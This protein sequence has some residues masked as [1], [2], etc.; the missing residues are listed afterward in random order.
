MFVIHPIIQSLAIL[1]GIYVFVLGIGRF[2]LLHLHHKTVFPWKRHVRLGIICLVAW[3]GGMLGGM[4]VV[5]RAWGVML[6]SGPHAQFALYMV[7]LIL[8]GLISGIYMNSKKKKRTVLPLLHGI[9]NVILLILALNQAR[10]GWPFLKALVFT[11][12]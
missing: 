4:L 9:N 11:P 5:R 2:R 6:Q 8:F 7:P 10:T 3:L 1:L 12:G